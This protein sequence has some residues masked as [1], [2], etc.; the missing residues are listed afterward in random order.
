M[1]IITK[2]FNI[3]MKSTKVDMGRGGKMPIH[4]VW[5][6]LVYPFPYCNNMLGL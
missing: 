5:I 6:F 3:I 2:F 1:W 4:K